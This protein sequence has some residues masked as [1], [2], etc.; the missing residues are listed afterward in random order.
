MKLISKEELRQIIS[1][2][3][4]GYRQ[5]YLDG[6]E[7][8]KYGVTEDELDSLIEKNSKRIQQNMEKEF[9]AE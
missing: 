4:I 8:E 1:Y 6:M 2:A 9:C 5:G 3:K 7:C